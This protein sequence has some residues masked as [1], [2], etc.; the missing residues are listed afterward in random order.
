MLL[1]RYY[2][3]VVVLLYISTSSS[4]S[5]SSSILYTSNSITIDGGE[6]SAERAPVP[7]SADRNIKQT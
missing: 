4:S 3:E 1:Y 7:R 2:V 6:E 5:S